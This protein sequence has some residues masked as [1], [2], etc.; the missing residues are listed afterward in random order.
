MLIEK[1]PI[2]KEHMFYF[3]GIDWEE[4]PWIYCS[5]AS[6]L[7]SHVRLAFNV[8]SEMKRK[9]MLKGSD[10]NE[11]APEKLNWS[12]GSMDREHIG[13]TETERRKYLF[14]FFSFFLIKW[15]MWNF[16]LRLNFFSP[17][18]W[19]NVLKRNRNCNNDEP[20]HF[21]VINFQWAI[22]RVSHKSSV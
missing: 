7:S 1:L 5:R 3:H 8:Q 21:F 20:H 4:E 2:R 13:T 10:G 22:K 9:N 11:S 18:N 16:F 6:I 14:S 15:E 12:N 17:S 19:L